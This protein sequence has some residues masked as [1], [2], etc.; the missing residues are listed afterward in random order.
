MQIQEAIIH[1]IIKDR[2]NPASTQFRQNALVNDEKLSALAEEV[3]RIYHGTSST[4][5]GDLKDGTTEQFPVFLRNYKQN[6]I[7]FSVFSRNLVELIVSKMNAAPASTGGYVLIVRYQQGQGDFLMVVIIKIKGKVN[8]DDDLNIIEAPILDF[9]KMHEA[10]RID[11]SKW[12]SQTSPC[13]SFVHKKRVDGG[14]TNYFRTALSCDEAT[15]SKQH[16]D[17]IM[18]A[19]K[20]FCDQKAYSLDQKQRV[21]QLEHEYFSE[22]HRENRPA[23]IDILSRRLFEEYPDEFIRFLRQGDYSVAEEFKPFRKSFIR[24]RTVVYNTPQLSFKFD[25]SLI[26]SRVIYDPES[27][28][29]T[30]NDISDALAQ[31]LSEI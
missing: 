10:A 19:V 29:I 12:L 7:T 4:A 6:D 16:T 20:D 9:E 15:D 8:I 11:L 2:G 27:R 14:A 23:S 24:L 21:K 17:N 1:K 18:R 25:A 5:Y 31:E 3:L 22:S 28:T 13:L 26:G 30:I